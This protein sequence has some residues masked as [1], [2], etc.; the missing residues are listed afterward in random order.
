MAV[1]DIARKSVHTR[2]RTLERSNAWVK[3]GAPDVG[4]EGTPEGGEMGKRTLWAL[5][6]VLVLG[7]V[8][9]G[10]GTAAD[11]GGGGDEGGN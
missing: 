9:A 11:N 8:G 2:R 1:L 6:L 4:G 10:C 3:L 5:V 7:I